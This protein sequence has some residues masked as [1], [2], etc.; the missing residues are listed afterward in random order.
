MTMTM[1]C[2]LVV[3]TIA[4]CSLPVST[5]AKQV[6]ERKIQV[7]EGHSVVF[8][9]LGP[10]TNSFR[11]EKGDYVRVTMGTHGGLLGGLMKRRVVLTFRDGK[12]NIA[13]KAEIKED[14]EKQTMFLVV[15]PKGVHSLIS[16]H[17]YEIS[18]DQAFTVPGNGEAVYIGDISLWHSDI[19]RVD[20]LQ[21]AFRKESIAAFVSQHPQFADHV[22]QVDAL[23]GNMPSPASQLIGNWKGIGEENSTETLSFGANGN[24]SVKDE[25]KTMF[26]TYRF[27]GASRIKISYYSMTRNVKGLISISTVPAV[28]GPQVVAIEVTAGALTMKLDDGHIERYKRAET[29]VRSSVLH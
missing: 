1:F 3:P 24:M 12:G 15:L 20:W 17:V 11:R 2:L 28:V 25:D 16:N 26:G 7:A 19:S 21:C 9:F 8:G 27:L 6:Q 29:E 23:C 22:V 13:G 14:F 4:L 10:F 5:A 18:A